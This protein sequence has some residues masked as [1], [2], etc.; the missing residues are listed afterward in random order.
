MC[1]TDLDI[2]FQVVRTF[3][4]IPEPAAQ[5]R[6]RSA[7]PRLA[8]AQP[9]S[10]ASQ[11]P[12][13]TL[14]VRNLPNRARL[15]RFQEHLKTLGGQDLYDSVYMP[16]DNRTGMSRGYA[17]VHFTDACLAARF[18][19]LVEGT[20]LPHSQSAK[21]LQIAGAKQQAVATR[22]KRVGTYSARVWVK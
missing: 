8:P 11:L 20:K 19:D 14:M 9:A 17:F 16:I 4:T 1:I 12:G 10:S 13:V 5:T 22:P 6:A 3:V 15:V 18:A 2:P 21:V 7:P